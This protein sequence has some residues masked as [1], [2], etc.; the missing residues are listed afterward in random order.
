MK[1]F[2]QKMN[3]MLIRKQRNLGYNNYYGFNKFFP[4]NKDNIHVQ[5]KM[6]YF[7]KREFS[8]KKK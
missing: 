2:L 6:A 4:N 5:H 1:Q 3:E 8:F 7:Q